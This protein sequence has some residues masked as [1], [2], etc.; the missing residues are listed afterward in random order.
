M[1]LIPPSRRPKLKRSWWLPSRVAAA[2]AERRAAAGS[3]PRA[4]EALESR[5]LLSTY[6]VDTHGTDTNAGNI[7]YPFRSIQRAADVV[8]PGDT[9]FIRGG[10]YRETVTPA[11]SGTKADPITFR[12]YPNE[13]VTVSGADLLTNWS[14]TGSGSIYKTRQGWNLGAGD[15]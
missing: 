7:D 3:P 6:Y 1:R 2:I 14:A 12:A 15:N 13:T 4:V 9:V 11:R 10:T 8:Q 5:V